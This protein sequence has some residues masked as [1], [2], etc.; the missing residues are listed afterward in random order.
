MV[1]YILI[2]NISFARQV[3]EKNITLKY[4]P[5]F[6]HSAIYFKDSITQARAYI[7][8]GAGMSSANWMVYADLYEAI[9]S[10]A[11]IDSIAQKLH[12]DPTIFK[13]RVKKGARYRI[14]GHEFEWKTWNISGFDDL[15]EKKEITCIVLFPDGLLSK[16]LHFSNLHESYRNRTF[17]RLFSQDGYM[18]YRIDESNH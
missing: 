1:I 8:Y 5:G 14:N 11:F 7:D 9:N 12:V 6:M 2:S 13:N 4:A 15:L 10:E 3:R 17:T 16:A 18:I